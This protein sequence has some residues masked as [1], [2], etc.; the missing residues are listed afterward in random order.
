MYA[1]PDEMVLDDIEVSKKLIDDKIALLDQYPVL[2]MTRA[3]AFNYALA[4][5]DPLSTT[6]LSGYARRMRSL[7]GMNNE[8]SKPLQS[9]ADDDF[10]G[11]H[12]L[13]H[14]L[15]RPF[16][17]DT[18]KLSVCLDLNCDHCGD[19]D[20]Y[21]FKISIVL[22][23][24]LKRFVNMEFRNYMESMFRAEA[25][26]HIFLKICWVDKKEMKDYEDAYADWAKA[27]AAWFAALPVPA[28]AIQ[29][30][31]TKA[32]N[33]LIEVLE[34]LRTDF[35]VATLHDCEDRDE[36]NDTRVFLSSTQLGTFKPTHEDGKPISDA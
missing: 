28:A 18:S 12:V 25:P 30:K 34:G 1:L 4:D 36:L 6:N 3:T 15:L 23:F 35:P 32:L 24:W 7:L 16:N 26:A 22:P 2:S 17:I 33:K 14:F 9:L 19:E 11:F 5:A 29:S 31:Y 21:S 27:R 8:T 10:G 20:P 13:E